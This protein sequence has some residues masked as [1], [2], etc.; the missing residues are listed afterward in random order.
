MQGTNLH[1]IRINRLLNIKNAATHN[2][3]N[4]GAFSLSFLLFNWEKFKACREVLYF[5]VI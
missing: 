4:K 1:L 2:N 5:I 3:I